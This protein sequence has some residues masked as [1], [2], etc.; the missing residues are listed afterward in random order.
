MTEHHHPASVAEYLDCQ[1]SYA[2]I[3]DQE[4][5]VTRYI[6]IYHGRTH[7]NK[8][9][10]FANG[11]TPPGDRQEPSLTKSAPAVTARVPPQPQA[12]VTAGL[13]KQRERLLN[14]AATLFEDN[15]DDDW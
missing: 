2:F 7:S 9:V 4:K 15:S 12:P 11:T 3:L 10:I 14:E 8:R 6:C 1:W 13:S 5:Q